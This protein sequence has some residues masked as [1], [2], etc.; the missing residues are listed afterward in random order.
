MILCIVL[1]VKTKKKSK[2]VTNDTGQK[3]GKSHKEHV[4]KKV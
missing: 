1:G 3:T 2:K 4:G